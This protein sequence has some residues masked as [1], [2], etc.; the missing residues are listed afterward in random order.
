ML[1]TNFDGTARGRRTGYE[2]K[3]RKK[4]RKKERATRAYEKMLMKQAHESS[5]THLRFG[6]GLGWWLSSGEY[7]DD[8]DKVA[9]HAQTA[10]TPPHKTLARDPCTEHVIAGHRSASSKY[11]ECGT[12]REDTNDL[13][14]EDEMR[15]G[16]FINPN[17]RWTWKWT[18]SSENN[19]LPRFG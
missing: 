15:S 16:C 8:V 1:I 17:E 12:D 5:D 4:E 19:C 18:S 10:Q 3:E 13:R 6:S 9:F 7:F 14:D 2:E 11:L